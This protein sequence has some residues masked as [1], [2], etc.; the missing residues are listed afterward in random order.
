M[1]RSHGAD[2]VADSALVGALAGAVNR[3]YEHG[4]VAHGEADP[5]A[6]AERPTILHPHSGADGAGGLAAEVGGAFIFDQDGFGA[7]DDG[8]GHQLWSN[9]KSVSQ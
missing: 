2:W 8:F 9:I 6:R 1:G 3:L 7:A 4:P 5:G